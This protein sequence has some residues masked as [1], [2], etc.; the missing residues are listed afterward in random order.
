ME[1]GPAAA[2]ETLTLHSQSPQGLCSP[3]TQALSPGRSR[4]EGNQVPS[5]KEEKSSTQKIGLCEE[6]VV[7]SWRLQ[8]ILQ[9]QTKNKSVQ[10]L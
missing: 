5:L 1:L 6:C 2:L 7:H 8:A 10:G 3:P 4:V 9:T